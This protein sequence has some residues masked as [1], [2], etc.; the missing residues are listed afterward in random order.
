MFT[1]QLD[2]IDISCALGCCRQLLWA[3]GK[4]ASSPSATH[5]TTTTTDRPPP[6]EQGSRMGLLPTPGKF[7]LL[8]GLAVAVLSREGQ[9]WRGTAQV[10]HPSRSSNSPTSTTTA[11]PRL[12]WQQDVRKLWKSFQVI[13]IGH[14][15]FSLARR[16]RVVTHRNDVLAHG[17][18]NLPKLPHATSTASG[19][20]STRMDHQLRHY[21][22]LLLDH[23]VKFTDTQDKDALKQV[24][25]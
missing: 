16:S 2:T 19:Q 9:G 10:S 24:P 1:I 21:S 20:H 5:S 13:D 22:A 18:R 8:L 15:M 23:A 11:S 7:L 14:T 6:T 3:R 4:T 25:T 12:C 17:Q